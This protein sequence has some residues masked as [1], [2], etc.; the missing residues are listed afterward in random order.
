M[1]FNIDTNSQKMM[2][3]Q[4]ALNVKNENLMMQVDEQPEGY[5]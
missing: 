5:D 3:Q 4:A 1:V 2:L